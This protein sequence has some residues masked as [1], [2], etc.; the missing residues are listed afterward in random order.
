MSHQLRQLAQRE[1]P[2]VALPSRVEG[3]GHSLELLVLRTQPDGGPS[4]HDG[5]LS[6]PHQHQRTPDPNH[7]LGKTLKRIGDVAREL[8]VTVVTVR[9]WSDTF[10]MPISRLGSQRRYPQKAVNRL[11]L[12]KHL[13]YKEGYTINGARQQYDRL[14]SCNW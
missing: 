8:D 2:Q 11:R 12:I 7:A 4:A 13:L 3:Q 9:F 1:A 10:P 6:K 5:L 14:I